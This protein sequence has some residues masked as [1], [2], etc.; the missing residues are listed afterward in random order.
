MRSGGAGRRQDGRSGSLRLEKGIVLYPPGSRGNATW[1]VRLSHE[2]R[3]A[4]VDCGTT[5]LELAKSRA[6]D[7]AERHRRALADAPPPRTFA[8]VADHYAAAK[9]A[10]E[11]E[12]SFLDRLKGEIGTKLVA[13]LV[14]GDLGV[15]ADRLYP[16]GK[17][18]T[19]NR[20]V[21]T[22]GA[23]VL[24]YAAEQGWCGYHV[25]H[26]L[27]E[28]EP[29][30]RR[31]EEGIERV[32][33]DAADGD[34]KVFL[35]FL[36]LQGW[37]ITETLTTPPSRVNLKRR[38]IKAWVGKAGR[39]K[40]IPLHPEVFIALANYLP[41][42]E[43]KRTLFPWSTRWGVY[44]QLRKLKRRLAAEG[45]VVDF[46]PHMARHW[47]GSELGDRL[48]PDRDI[49]DAGTWT[50]TK[51]VARY[52]KARAERARSTIESLEIRGKNGGT[53]EKAKAVK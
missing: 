48:V 7:L 6:R 13:T 15:A 3:R 29:E 1:Y 36:F 18:Q 14:P 24:H 11:R 28:P 27:R 31:P 16:A 38:Q 34:L 52:N 42:R 9:G 23:A 51:S 43:G 17:P 37:R 25:V 46:T 2:G 35:Q 47:F 8:E 50:T 12:R 49:M 53:E 21:M 41:K 39:W 45:T 40:W 33:I 22:P 32:L 19:K 10:S 44:R 20:A 26:K 30:T 4:E 5:R